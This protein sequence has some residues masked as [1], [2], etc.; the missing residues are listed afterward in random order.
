MQSF[1]LAALAGIAVAAP[2]DSMDYK[3][4]NFIAKHGKSYATSEEYAARKALFAKMDAEIEHFN[5]TETTSRHGHNFLSDYTE[6]ER[7][8]MTGTWK[9]DSS[10]ATET[11]IVGSVPDWTTGVD[12]VTQGSVS[13]VKDQG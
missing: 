4:I 7:S 3:F 9:V 12:W 8:R 10:I 13:P 2:M 1:I 11:P 6:F 5:A